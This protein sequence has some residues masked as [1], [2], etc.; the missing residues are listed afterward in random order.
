MFSIPIFRLKIFHDRDARSS[1]PCVVSKITEHHLQL[2]YNLMVTKNATKI[3]TS[4]LKRAKQYT[5]AL[6]HLIA[7]ETR[8]DFVTRIDFQTNVTEN[9][10]CNENLL[11]A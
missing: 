6:Q 9:I 11:C 4:L 8:N 10:F 2:V 7:R 3:S 5:L 1:F